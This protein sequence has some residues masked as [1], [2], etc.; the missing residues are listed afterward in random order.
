[1]KL[2]V[3]SAGFLALFSWWN[4]GSTEDSV[5]VSEPPPI[6]SVET[7]AIPI[8]DNYIPNGLPFSHAS[9]DLPLSEQLS[10][11]CAACHSDI[12]EQWTHDP[13]RSGITSQKLLKEWSAHNSTPECQNCHLPLFGQQ[14]MVSP[15][16]VSG[17]P[18]QPIPIPNPNFKP[19]LYVESVGCASCHIRDGKIVGQTSTSAPHTIVHSNSLSQSI[20]CH[21]CH[22][23]QPAGYADPIY[24]TYAEWESSSFAKAGVQCQDCHMSNIPTTTS[25]VGTVT[26]A[27]HGMSLSIRQALR[28]EWVDAPTIIQRGILANFNVTII[29]SGAGH[30]IPTGSPFEDNKFL[31]EVI[32]NGKNLQKPIEHRMG[33]VFSDDAPKK[34]IERSVIPADGTL[35]FQ[36]PVNIGQKKLTG[37]AVLRISYVERDNPS[38]LVEY[39]IEIR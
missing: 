30:A 24:N 18:T 19:N 21:S 14:P 10:G 8:I 25:L 38:T 35:S 7:P 5:P 39:P 9:T 26:Q 29:N 28:V 34:I 36:I 13:H 31:F 2:H 32:Q 20:A 17:D 15:T 3:A 1:M 16:F 27:N 22:Q 37:R 33:I 23:G 11:S 12:F 4:F 6:T